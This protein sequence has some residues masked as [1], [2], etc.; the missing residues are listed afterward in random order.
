MDKKFKITLVIII[1]IFAALVIVNSYLW[2]VYFNLKKEFEVKRNPEATPTLT[3]TETPSSSDL[4]VIVAEKEPFLS[5]QEGQ[6]GFSLD[7]IVVGSMPAPKNLQKNPNSSPVEYYREGEKVNVLVLYL[8]IKAG[9][10]GACLPAGL[11]Q[12]IDEVGNT[13]SFNNSFAP[14]ASSNGVLTAQPA[15]F[16]IPNAIGTH[17]LTT[18]GDSN[19]FFTITL[20]EDGNLTFEKVPVGEG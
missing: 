18:G 3:P 20:T 12:V 6:N 13:A 10:K 11:R 16:A 5:W 2:F 4:K 7:K 1:L 8:T 9:S 19:M 15:I 14:C 17:L